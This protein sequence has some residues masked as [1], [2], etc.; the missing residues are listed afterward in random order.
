MA[1]PLDVRSLPDTDSVGRPCL[2]LAFGC[3][4]Q[5]NSDRPVIAIAVLRHG[6]L[7]NQR[8]PVVRRR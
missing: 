7:D 4:G 3:C 2:L 1:L 8:T 6:H 5:G